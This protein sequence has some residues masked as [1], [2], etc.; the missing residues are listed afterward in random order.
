MYSEKNLSWFALLCLLFHWH[1]KDFFFNFVYTGVLSACLYTICVQCLGQPGE[2]LRYP[3]T[4]VTT[5]VGDHVVPGI[6][7]W[8]SG[9]AAMLLI[10]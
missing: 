8:S 6:E 10:Y 4:G 3:G 5:V 7:P 1:L 2:G 9:R